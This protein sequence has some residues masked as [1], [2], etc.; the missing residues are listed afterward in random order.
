VNNFKK[1]VF[2]AMSGGVDSSVSAALLQ[3]EGYDVTGVFMKVW[4]PN[5]LECNW[6]EER[7]DAMKV[8][9]KLKVPFLT[10]N[11]EEEYKKEVADYMVAQYRLGNTPNPDVM[12]NMKIK[13]GVFFDRAKKDGADYIATGHY[14]L[15]NFNKK[16]QKYEMKVSKDKEKDQ[17]YFLWSIRQEKLKDTFFPVGSM[18]KDEVRKL[19]KKFNLPVFDKKDSQGICFLGKVNMKNFLK[20]Y[21]EERKGDVLSTEGE[22]IGHHDG[23]FFLTLG[24][25][26]GFVITKKG[27]DDSP[28]YVVSK[29]IENNTITVCS[30]DDKDRLLNASSVRIGKSNWI[31][32]EPVENKEYLARIRH[33]QEL[34]KCLFKNREWHFK[35][36]QKALAI[37]QSLVVY[38]GDTCLGGGIVEEVF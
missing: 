31:S 22:I 11:L 5:F 16:T 23:A 25:R 38:Q 34:Q 24:Q 21:I 10:F 35:E 12:C 18:K 3:K 33:R 20:E 19:A 13:F 8:C 32:E 36:K 7:L 14:T 28:M 6:R 37:G 9:A 26:H 29:D 2:V 30:E 1:K 17:T 4:Q 15:K 27:T